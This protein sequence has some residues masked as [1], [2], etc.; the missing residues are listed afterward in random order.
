MVSRDEL[1][2]LEAIRHFKEGQ[3]A[4]WLGD[5]PTARREFTKC[6]TAINHLRQSAH[7]TGLKPLADLARIAPLKRDE[8]ID[9]V[10]Q[11]KRPKNEDP[12][13]P[14]TYCLILQGSNKA[15]FRARIQ[16][17]P[18]ILWEIAQKIA[19][20]EKT[21]NTVT[22]RSWQWVEVK[23]DAGFT[24]TFLLS[25]SNGTIHAQITTH[26]FI[27]SDTLDHLRE[28]VA[29]ALVDKLSMVRRT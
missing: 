16:L 11:G 13:F 25:F 21:S 19:I 29:Q 28:N 8:R 7:Y 5:E 23:P 9:N 14:I 3:L 24:G 4:A 20:T 18:K 17:P 12:I 26:D 6:N 15:E 27:D 1:I 10:Q 2:A 22:N